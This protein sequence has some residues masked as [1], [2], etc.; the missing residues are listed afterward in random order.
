MV[1]SGGAIYEATTFAARLLGLAFLREL[2]SGHGL[3]IPRCRSV[4]TFGMRFPLDVAFLDDRGRAIRVELD[5]PARRI[6]A[7]RGAFAVLETRAGDIE[8]F[9]DQ[10][11]PRKAGPVDG[12][13]E[14]Y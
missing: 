7:T 4:H 2:P 1:R 10:A 9:V 5:V 3:L 11:P 13:E 6:L 14:S 12:E 8:L